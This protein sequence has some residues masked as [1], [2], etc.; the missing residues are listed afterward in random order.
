MII[1]K[2]LTK[3]YAGDVILQDI[4]FRFGNN[5]KIGLV[6]RN[7]CG[8]STLF[9]LIAGQEATTSG[10]IEYHGD[11]VGYIPQEFHFP[12][13]MLGEYFEKRLEHPWEFYKIETLATQLEFTNF[14]PYQEIPTMSEGQKMKVKMIEVLLKDPTL[15]LIDEP[16]NHLDINGIMWLENYIKNLN[17]TV[18]MISHDRQFLNNT[19]DE[20]IEIENKKMYRFVG[21]YDNYKSEKLKLINKWDEEYVRFLRKKAQLEKLLINV[22]KIS[23]GKKRGRAMNAA[24]KRIDREIVQNEKEKYESKVIKDVN[25]DTDVRSTKLILR[26]DNVAKSY[27]DKKVFADLD[28]ELRGKEKVWLF[29]PNGAGKTTLVKMIMGEESVTDGE[30]TLGENITVGYFAQK[31]TALN[32]DQNLYDQFIY[33]TGCHYGT[34]YKFLEDFLFTSD[35]L[36]KPVKFLSPGQRARYAFAIFAYKDYDFLILDEPTNHLDI[37]TKEVIEKSLSKFNGTL[38]LVSHDRY[39]VESVGI[40]KVLNLRD[41]S[42][43]LF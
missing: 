8:K 23:D 34:V 27:E 16:T 4:E 12:N 38:L 5:R 18:V 24:R 11:I 29:G 39:F 36:K 13:E 28:F 7:G 42:L 31:Q 1:A 21:D 35:D 10:S 22:S 19:V 3:A 32:F 25:F 41:G 15:I 37:E 20:I 40:D 43:E 30:L 9:R 26:L 14:D 6:G 33:E 17:K 2:N